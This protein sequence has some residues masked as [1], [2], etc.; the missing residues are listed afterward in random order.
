MLFYVLS[1]KFEVAEGA[2]ETDGDPTFLT[3]MDIPTRVLHD[4]RSGL[5]SQRFAN[6]P[7]TVAKSPIGSPK[8]VSL[9]GRHACSLSYQSAR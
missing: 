4:A 8:P 1:L 5:I 3:S 7:P 9:T 2:K 6:L